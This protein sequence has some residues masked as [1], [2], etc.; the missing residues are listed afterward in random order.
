MA[1]RGP[2]P[3]PARRL[4]YWAAVATAA[5]AAVGLGFGVTTPARSGPNCTSDCVTSPYTDVAAFVPR[6]YLWIYAAILMV[7]SYVV[8][9]VCVHRSVAAARQVYSQVALSFALISAGVAVLA[10]GVQLMVVQPSLP[11]GELDGLPLWSMYNPSG[12]FIALENLTYLLLGPSWLF[13]AA[14]LPPARGTVRATRVVLTVAGA[15]T[16]VSLVGL[17]AF[18]GRDLGYRYEVVA[19]SVGWIALIVIG[20]LPPSRSDATSSP[21]RAGR[22]SH[23]ERGA[24]A[25][26]PAGRG[27]R[28]HPRPA[29]IARAIVRQRPLRP[30][31]PV[32]RPSLVAEDHAVA[33]WP[34]RR[35]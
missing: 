25:R 17:A 28:P 12:L 30:P 32:A 20:V 22:Q 6:D 14:A 7:L 3:T 5:T 29:M 26:A 23:R 19:L 10:Y 8:L 35:P 9:V 34:Q 31:V 2:A 15:L 21:C 24:G 27:K 1:D 11:K 18:Y 4:G 33:D 13:L 16:L